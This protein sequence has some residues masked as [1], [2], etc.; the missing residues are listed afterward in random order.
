MNPIDK[1]VRQGVE[2]GVALVDFENDHDEEKCVRSLLKW[3]KQAISDEREMIAEK[4]EELA[5]LAHSQWSGWMEYMFAWGRVEE[6][7]CFIIP[8]ELYERWSRQMTT[9]YS[10]LS[11]REKDSDRKEADRVIAMLNNDPDQC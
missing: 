3:K 10:Q 2:L 9:P 5:E 7:G 11:E 4:R 6:H 1:V 8:K